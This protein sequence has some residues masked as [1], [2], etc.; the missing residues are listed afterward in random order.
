MGLLALIVF[1]VIAIIV[2]KVK[3]LL[4]LYVCFVSCLYFLR[5]EDELILIFFKSNDK[6]LASQ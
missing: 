1:G 6:G 5:R 2:V 4:F 3:F